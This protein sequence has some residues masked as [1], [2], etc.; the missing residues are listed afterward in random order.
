MAKEIK[1]TIVTPSEYME[2][3]YKHPTKYYI[4]DCLGNRNYFHCRDRLKVQQEVDRIYG[5]GKYSVRVGSD[6][7][8]GE[9]NARGSVNSRSK[10]GMKYKDILNKQVRGF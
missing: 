5:K 8:G 6:T 7:K 3:D 1:T 4:V 9:V 10:A 2:E